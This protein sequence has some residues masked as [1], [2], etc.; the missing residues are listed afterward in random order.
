MDVRVIN[1]PEGLC[2]QIG[3]DGV[4]LSPDQLAKI[5]LPHYQAE[6]S[7]T[8]QVPGIGLGLSMVASLVWSVD[9]TCRAY[10]REGGPGV[11]VEL[12]LPIMDKDQEDHN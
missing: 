7:F 3:D 5:W 10:N 6:R 12:V 1:M 2:L 11:I 8:G 9:G 4:T